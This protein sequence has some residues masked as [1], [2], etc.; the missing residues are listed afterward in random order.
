MSETTKP[1]SFDPENA[2]RNIVT[3]ANWW[4][5]RSKHKDINDVTDALNYYESAK[6]NSTKD[7]SE[8]LGALYGVIEE[9][10]HFLVSGADSGAFEK[11][12]QVMQGVEKRVSIVDH[13]LVG[14]QM[15]EFKKKD[16]KELS[17][18]VLA[19]IYSLDMNRAVLLEITPRVETENK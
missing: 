2:I 14:K 13:D 12:E 5:E 6:K 18:S 16:A 10:N 7:P 15:E 3:K 4:Q 9:T 19:L 8:A 11:L 1:V 17:R